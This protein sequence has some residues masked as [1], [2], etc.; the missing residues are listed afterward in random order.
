M[1]EILTPNCPLCS[2]PPV[3][4]FGETAFCGND[5]CTLFCWDPSV[6]LD[7]NLMDAGVVKLPPMEEGGDG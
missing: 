5:G 4:A 2:R 3:M 7:A 1:P 6:S